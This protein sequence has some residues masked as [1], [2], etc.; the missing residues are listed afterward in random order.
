MYAAP[1]L[2]AIAMHNVT[3][4]SRT[5]HERRDNDDANDG[6]TADQAQYCTMASR[7][8]GCFDA[9]RTF[10]RPCS[11]PPRPRNPNVL[12]GPCR[13]LAA[14]RCRAGAVVDTGCN[15]CTTTAASC[16]SCPTQGSGSP[17]VAP[18][19]VRPLLHCGAP[20]VGRAADFP[21]RVEGS[22][23]MRAAVPELHASLRPG[24]TLA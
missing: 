12:M 13:V 16:S 5:E 9:A 2:I 10:L 22:A 21:P 23:P 24:P 20:S 11:C 17:A 14:R 1:S 19:R 7:G 4:V 3:R 15:A 8:R 18:G 6:L